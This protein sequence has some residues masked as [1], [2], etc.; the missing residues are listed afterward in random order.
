[1]YFLHK[2]KRS[3]RLRQRLLP[4]RYA[5]GLEQD[6]RSIREYDDAIIAPYGGYEGAD[7]YYAR[8][9]AGPVLTLIGKPTLILAA[10]DDPMIPADSVTRWPLAQTVRLEMPPNG[11]HTGF[12]GKTTAPG[13]FWAAER[14]L[15]FIEEKNSK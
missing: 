11:G 8:S 9:S 15:A 2:L 12:V 6:R 13:K 7:D 5:L 4:E 1:M 10:G 3:Y 14:A